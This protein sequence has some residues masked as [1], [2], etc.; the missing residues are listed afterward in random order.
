MALYPS[1]PPGNDYFNSDAERKVFEKANDS[2]IIK[3]PNNYLFHSLRV[4]DANIRLTGEVDYV[5]MDKE[6]I[7][8][9]EVKGG[10]V[11][12]DSTTNQW[13]TMGGTKKQDPFKQVCSY[14]FAIRDKHFPKVFSGD[15][16]DQKLKFG[17]GVLFPESGKP[18][19]FNKYSNEFKGYSIEYSP[20][21]MYLKSDHDRR[22]AFDIYLE[23]LKEYWRNYPKYSSRGFNGVT[24]KD[25]NKIKNYFRTDLIFKVPISEHLSDDKRETKFYTEKQTSILDSINKNS[26][27]GFFINGGPGTGK[28]ILALE[29]AYQK[30]L[31]GHKVLLLCFNKC[32]AVNLEK[33]FYEAFPEIKGDLIEISTL[34]SIFLS[35]L[36]SHGYDV[37]V[38][39]GE[40]FWQKSLPELFKNAFTDYQLDE[41]F[42]YIIIDEGQDIFRSLYMDCIELLL[43]GGW[44]SK[45]WVIFMDK[46]FQT[47]YS[48]FDN[49]Y[50]QLFKRSYPAV[51]W[52]LDR[53]CRNTPS[54]VKKAH[55]HTGLKELECLKKDRL[56]PELNFYDTFVDLFHSV[57]NLIDNLSGQDIRL[58]SITLLSDKNTIE[59]FLSTNSAR[60]VMLKENAC[61]IPEDKVTLSTPHSFKGLENDFIIYTGRDRF[62]PKNSNMK[63]E[64]Y[65][66]YTRA[67]TQ[68]YLFFNK[69]IRER[70]T[71]YSNDVIRADIKKNLKS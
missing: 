35:K 20:E 37:E 52:D 50:L 66:S 40:N 68:L 58:G 22:F 48:D 59:R 55:V 46:E 23:R 7:L 45:A 2:E 6:F 70:L 32:L 47:I 39:D 61:Q 26:E 13:W 29:H 53:N 27:F 38:V 11:K 17:Y 31:T 62:D 67:R 56:K 34:H 10:E 3:S 64:Y 21:I 15:Y 42:D 18:L 1:S 54:I 24:G 4:Q 25:L 8:F 41:L 9:L 28:S 19:G 5:Y 14:L 63:V 69:A 36:N 71:E 43:K 65:V 12:Y 44:D 49:E 33:K 60:Y 16:Y 57:E 30:A 51:L